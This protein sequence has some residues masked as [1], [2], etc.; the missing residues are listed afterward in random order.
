MRRQKRRRRLTAPFFLTTRGDNAAE[1][2]RPRRLYRRLCGAPE[3]IVMVRLT[4]RLLLACFGLLL[5]LAGNAAGLSMYLRN[6]Y[7][8]YQV[9]KDCIDREQL[10]AEDA[11]KA[12]DA[13]AKIE[14]YYMQRDASIN[15]DKLVK[16]A[17]S[18]KNQA[19]KMMK[20]TSKIDA[21]EFCRGSLNDLVSKVHDIEAN[22]SPK[23]SGS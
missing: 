17:V 11:A 4:L 19:F 6:Y 20:E 16:Q 2:P 9:V 7:T 1:P 13:I 22:A 10:S 3:E 12:K 14:A 18:N 15:K 5:P 23:K 21:R 8:E